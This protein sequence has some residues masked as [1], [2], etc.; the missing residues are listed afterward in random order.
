MDSYQTNSRSLAVDMPG[1]VSDSRQ[2]DNADWHLALTPLDLAFANWKSREGTETMMNKAAKAKKPQLL[3]LEQ[4]TQ[5]INDDF[6]HPSSVLCQHPKSC[7]CFIQ[8]RIYSKHRL[9]LFVAPV[10]LEYLV[11]VIWQ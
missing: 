9:C 5:V 1:T 11:K 2:Y 3:K 8:V 10:V 7:F 6:E 4:G